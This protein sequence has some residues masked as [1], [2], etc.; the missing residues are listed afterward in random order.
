LSGA[1]VGAGILLTVKLENTIT[2]DDAIGI[3]TDV[4]A[5]DFANS[6]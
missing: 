6:Y 1:G 2:I 5:F 3:L 4:V